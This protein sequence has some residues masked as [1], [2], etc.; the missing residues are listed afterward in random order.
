MQLDEP[1][2]DDQL[3]R[4]PFA[5]ALVER[6]D[7]LYAAYGQSQDK[8]S[9][10]F[11]AHIHAPWGAGKTSVLKL[12][13]QLM[14]ESDRKAP[15][16]SQAPR[17][18]VV[19][20]NA[21]EHERRNPPWWPL[22]EKVKH[23]CIRT[24]SRPL[25]EKLKQEHLNSLPLP[26]RDWIAVLRALKIQS[27][28]IWWKT[29]TEKLP[30]ILALAVGALLFWLSRRSGTATPGASTNVELILKL[31]GAGLAAYAAFLAASRFIVFGSMSAA[32]LFDNISNDPLQRVKRLFEKIIE[33]PRM[34]VCIIIDD[35]D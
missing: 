31:I 11:A 24:L 14:T 16:G 32:Q 20:F 18:V 33:K 29:K 7:K 19:D 34:P 26:R 25:I 15:D 5:R 21:W 27:R 13:R 9:N 22:I 1:T 35:L 17:W 28:W 12:M 8:E 23:E 4:K 30:L 2:A 10:G 3:Y 6:L